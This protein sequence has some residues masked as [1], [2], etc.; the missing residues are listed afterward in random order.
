MNTSKTL[1]ALLVAYLPENGGW[2]KKVTR[3]GQDYDRELMFYGRG[4]VRTGIFLN[5]L[6]IDHRK[7]GEAGV[8][9][10][11]DQYEAALAASKAVVGRNG[12]IDWHGG[13]CPVERGTLVDI[14]DR[15]GFV[16]F[17][18]EALDNNN[19]DD[20][21]WQRGVCGASSNEIIAYRLN[22]TQDTNT[23]ANDDRLEADL[24]DCIGQ[25]QSNDDARDEILYEL[26]NFAA[27]TKTS[28]DIGV[29]TEIAIWLSGKGY[30]KQ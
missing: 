15:D 11:R 26:A 21:F 19:A 16:H 27:T 14:K 20:I 13:E 8:K 29:A 5:E 7:C 6:A 1:L 22:Q 30:R 25:A 24:N 23:R 9:I 18:V 4:N 28:L 2:P 10:T 12:W 17:G 3:I